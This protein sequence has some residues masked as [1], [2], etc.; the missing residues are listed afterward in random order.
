ME[1]QS[2]SDDGVMGR[3][4]LGKITS[5]RY[6]DVQKWVECVCEIDVLRW[7]ENL[8]YMYISYWR[9]PQKVNYG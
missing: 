1:S 2:G 7:T 9:E 8:F 3:C 5:F 4:F 6:E